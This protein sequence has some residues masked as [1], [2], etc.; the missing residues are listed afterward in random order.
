V[1]PLG[2]AWSGVVFLKVSVDLKTGGRQE[3]NLAHLHF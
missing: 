2:A 1:K 3:T